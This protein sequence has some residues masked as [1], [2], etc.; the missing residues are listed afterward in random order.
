MFFFKKSKKTKK[1]NKETVVKDDVVYTKIKA[2][3]VVDAFS[4][5]GKN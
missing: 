5:L 1:Q 4:K 2:N 3:A